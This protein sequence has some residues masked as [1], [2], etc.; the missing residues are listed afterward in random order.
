ML[1]SGRRGL[2]LA[3]FLPGPIAQRAGNA[4]GSRSR[5]AALRTWRPPCLSRSSW[6]LPGEGSHP[7]LAGRQCCACPAGCRFSLPA[8]SCPCVQSCCPAA[9]AVQAGWWGCCAWCLQAGAA[10][11]CSVWFC[12]E[13]P[14][15]PQGHLWVAD[16]L[17]PGQEM[18]G[19]V[20][21][22]T[23][24]LLGPGFLGIPTLSPSFCPMSPH[25]RLL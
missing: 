19:A 10:P 21:K 11:S 18:Q 2:G 23:R 17:Q 13:P 7:L 14:H 3:A 5:A 16:A 24:P 12:S 15:P 22:C 8:I 9:P 25:V 6:L 4:V 1:S 20:L